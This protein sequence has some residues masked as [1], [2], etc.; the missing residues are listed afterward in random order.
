MKNKA[1]Q[2]RFGFAL[3]GIAAGLRHESSVRTQTTAGA[4]VLAVLLWR[5]PGAV[6]WALLIMN[7]GAVLSAELMNTALEHA[8]DHLNPAI[9][10]AIKIAKDCAAGAVLVLTLTAVAT[11]VAFLAAT[12]PR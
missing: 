4:L 2:H 5:R 10:P 8:L 7:C 1:F 9:H 3:Q 12:W 11:F 6:W